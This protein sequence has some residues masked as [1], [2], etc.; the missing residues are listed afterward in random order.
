MKEH[1]VTKSE[2]VTTRQWAAAK[3]EGVELPAIREPGLVVVEMGSPGVF[4]GTPRVEKD[5]F[6]RGPIILG[7]TKYDHGLTITNGTRVK[8]RLPGPGKR[9]S[10]VVGLDFGEYTIIG[11]TVFVVKVDGKEVAR[12]QVPRGYGP[13][14]PIEADL[15]GA[16]EFTIELIDEEQRWKHDHGSWVEAKIELEDG[17]FIALSDLPIVKESECVSTDPPFSFTYGG[18]AS[19]EI[20]WKVTR[21]S[22]DLGNRSIGHDVTYNDPVTGLEVLCKG[23]EYSDF[24]VVEW[25]LHFKNTGAKDTPIIENIQALDTV[26][27]RSDPDEFVLHHGAGCTNSAHDYEPFSDVLGP[28]SDRHFKP[29]GGRATSG[30]WPYFNVELAD[31]GVIAVIGWIGQWSAEFTRDDSYGL[32]IQGGQELTHFTLHPGEKTRSPLIAL[33]FYKG[34]AVRSQNI[35]RRWLLAHNLPRRDGKLPPVIL[36]GTSGPQ[37]YEMVFATDEDQMLFIRRYLEEKIEL[38]YWEMDAGWYP[39]DGT[40]APTGTWEADRKRFPK[41]LRAVSDYARERGLETIVWFE[42]ERVRADTYLFDEHRDWLLTFKGS[43]YVLDLG[44][45]EAREWLT[46]HIDKMLVEEGI[47]VYRQDFNMDPLDYWRANDA[48][49]RQGITEIRHIEGLLMFWDELLRRHPNLL[50]DSVSSGHRRNDLE[51]VRRSISFTRTDFMMEPVSQQAMAY[52]I[53]SWMP[54]HA[55]GEKSI[56]TYLFRSSFTA[57]H[58]IVAQDVRNKDLDYNLLRKL[59]R[60][61]REYARFYLGDYYPLTSYSLDTD[62]WIA[63]QFDLPEEGA[64]LVQAFRRQDSP[65]ESARYK[66]KNLDEGAKYKVRNLDGGEVVYTG[67][68][69]AETGLDVKIDEKPGAV[70][71]IYK[72]LSG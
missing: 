10:A 38:D 67:K 66:L 34:D 39:N 19:A 55:G 68:E 60:Q 7:D 71:F 4:G 54:Y 25:T 11:T 21:S 14:F 42:P 46:N 72:K 70:V 47:D 44:N 27:T 41:G 50:I 3:F 52:G 36:F 5:R 18:E 32:R 24:P 35:W 58:S 61:W 6:L 1:I 15:G 29:R 49:D 59:T 9:F 40:W 16:S 20:E 17:S 2:M 30:A 63:W 65:Y 37:F 53:F 33:L 64:G 8:V 12:R 28:G 31:S 26:F 22:R 23:V 57:P 62:V 48:P 51:G 13:G 69:L 56:D 45:P 43:N